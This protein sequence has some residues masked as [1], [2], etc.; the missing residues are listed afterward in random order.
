MSNCEKPT[1]GLIVVGFLYQLFQD[2]ERMEEMNE[3]IGE[4]AASISVMLA[5]LGVSEAEYIRTQ[6]LAFA[7]LHENGTKCKFIRTAID[8]DPGDSNVYVQMGVFASSSKVIEMECEL[9]VRLND[10]LCD[11][12]ADKL[13][14]AFTPL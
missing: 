7:V 5:I 1:T 12:H 11:W 14:F 3:N 13:I 8:R 10:A 2:G 4:S 6:E 9:A